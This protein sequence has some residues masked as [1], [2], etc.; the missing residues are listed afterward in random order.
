MTEDN[1]VCSTMIGN[2]F[3]IRV[4]KFGEEGS[5]TIHFMTSIYTPEGHY[6]GDPKFAIPLIMQKGIKPELIPDEF[7]QQIEDK[8]TRCCSIGFCEK[9]QKWYGWS[10]RSMYGFGIGDEVKEGDA[11]SSSGLTDECLAQHPEWYLSLPVGFKAKTLED[12]KRM[13]IAF[14]DSVS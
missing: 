4:T 13:A 5:N 1:I 10:H 6:V 11:T 9:E 14:A 8:P 7:C 3:E 12:A 2:L